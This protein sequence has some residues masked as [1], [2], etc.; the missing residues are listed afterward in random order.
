MGAALGRRKGLG[1]GAGAALIQAAGRPQ[2]GVPEKVLK[3]RVKVALGRVPSMIATTRAFL[4]GPIQANGPSVVGL[5]VFS[6]KVM[7]GE[8]RNLCR[9]R[10]PCG[11][12]RRR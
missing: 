8:T 1:I 10:Q 7:F 11:R 4:L 12:V 3:L 9:S 6:S 5:L 2:D